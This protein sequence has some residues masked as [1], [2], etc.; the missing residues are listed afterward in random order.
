M[1]RKILQM[2]A[3]DAFPWMA[4]RTANRIFRLFQRAFEILVQIFHVIIPSGEHLSQAEK[5]PSGDRA[6]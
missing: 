4:H 1:S 5:R 3:F 6:A 2:F